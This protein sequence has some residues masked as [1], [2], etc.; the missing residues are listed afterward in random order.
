MTE[1]HP[2]VTA[3]N[4]LDG[5]GSSL[6][7]REFQ[8]AFWRVPPPDIPDG[9]DDFA[10]WSRGLPRT[11]GMTIDTG[12][13]VEA[14]SFTEGRVALASY[15]FGYDYDFP[16]GHV[17]FHRDYWL[18]KVLDLFGLSGVK[19][20]LHNRVPGIKSSGL[21]GSATAA[22]AVCILAN[23]LSGA[24]FAPEQLVAMASLLEQDLG[25]SITGTQEQSNVLFG[26][27]TDYIWFP[28]GVPGGRGAYGT[29]IRRTLMEERDYP[30]LAARLRIFHTGDERASADVN[31]VWR[32]KLAE[33]AGFEIHRRKLEIAFDYREGL[34]LRD[35]QRVAFAMADYRKARTELSADYMTSRSWDIQAQCDAVGAQSFP[36]G[37]GGG[38]AVMVFG[39]RPERLEEL[40]H[41]LGKVYRR[42]DVR[43][44][45]RGHV[46]ENVTAR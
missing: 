30:E 37:A 28:W 18:L 6:D 14:H 2:R 26:G 39:P 23:A 16:A 45:S 8:E 44:L 4:R 13:V 22:T 5:P 1:L 25:I 43:L 31:S 7:L 34:R 35:W 11:V 15:D 24:G 32:R 9:D 36:L 40:D 20:E 33:P 19:F 29:S 17:P 46:I 38:G 27:V 42:I 21:G 12:S 41:L 10:R 3:Y